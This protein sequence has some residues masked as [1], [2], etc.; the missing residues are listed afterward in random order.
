M[1]KMNFYIR[2]SNNFYK[3]ILFKIN[4]KNKEILFKT[5]LDID[6]LIII[7]F[8]NKKYILLFELKL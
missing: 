4:L 3:N 2:F 5:E 1:M 6:N 7:T 8:L